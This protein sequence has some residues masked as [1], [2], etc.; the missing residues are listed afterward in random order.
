MASLGYQQ[1]PHRPLRIQECLSL[2]LAL[3][4]VRRSARRTTLPSRH[5]SLRSRC[6]CPAIGIQT[7]GEA[8]CLHL[9]PPSLL[10][11]LPPPPPRADGAADLRMPLPILAPNHPPRGLRNPTLSA[12]VDPS[13]TSCCDRGLVRQLILRR[14]RESTLGST[15]LHRT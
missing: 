6:S 3:P 10:P 7:A 4:A 8:A 2:S 1:H 15:L 9:R 12:V 11:L 14:G 13:M 5:H